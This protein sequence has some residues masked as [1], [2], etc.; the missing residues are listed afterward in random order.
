MNTED[1]FGPVAAGKFIFRIKL[2]TACIGGYTQINSQRA[3]WCRCVHVVC[4][5][6]ALCKGGM[7]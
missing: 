3:F 1:F 2:L 4:A 7:D 5:P 6:A